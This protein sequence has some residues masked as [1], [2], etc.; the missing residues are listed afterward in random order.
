MPAGAGCNP[1][2]R[3]GGDRRR[4]NVTGA[5]MINIYNLEILEVLRDELGDFLAVDFIFDAMTCRPG[6]AED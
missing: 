5:T 1:P 6:S 2:V 4:N 3:R